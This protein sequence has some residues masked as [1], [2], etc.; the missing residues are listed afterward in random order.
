[1]A[2]A[3]TLRGYPTQKAYHS[4]HR[5]ALYHSFRIAY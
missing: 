3:N 2:I 4:P 5:T 1:M